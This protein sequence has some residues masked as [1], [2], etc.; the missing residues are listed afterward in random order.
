MAQ[1]QGN[2]IKAANEKCFD[3]N[4]LAAFVSRVTNGGLDLQGRIQNLTI[5]EMNNVFIEYESYYMIIFG[6]IIPIG[7]REC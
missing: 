6:L 3:A 2:I 7:D 4:L 5:F 1:Y